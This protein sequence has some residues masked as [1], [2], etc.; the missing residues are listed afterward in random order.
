MET[1]DLFLSEGEDAALAGAY[2][3][4]AGEG[5][6]LSAVIAADEVDIAPLRYRGEARYDL[7]MTAVELG[8][9]VIVEQVAVDDEVFESHLIQCS[10]YLICATNGGAE[11]EVAYHKGVAPDHGPQNVARR[12]VW[13]ID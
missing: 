4:L 5:V 3:H 6:E 13:V 11:M 1:E 2:V 9:G 8:R 10:E 12:P 7:P